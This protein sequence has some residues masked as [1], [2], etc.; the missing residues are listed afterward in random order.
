[1]TTYAWPSRRGK[2]ASA[3]LRRR[4]ARLRCTAPPIL[5]FPATTPTRGGPGSPAATITTTPPLRRRLPVRKTRR[6]AERPRREAYGRPLGGDTLPP[7][8]TPALQNRPSGTSTHPGTK[9]MLSLA[10]PNI[11]LI[12]AFHRD[13]GFEVEVREKV[14]AGRSLVKGVQA[15]SPVRWTTTGGEA[16]TL[17][18]PREKIF[19]R[20]RKAVLPLFWGPARHCGRCSA[21][22]KRVAPWVNLIRHSVGKGR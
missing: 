6:K 10:S 17:E 13:P 15:L 18:A 1:M 19:A 16:T 14:T 11:G 3:S 2:A 8:G 12:G 9:A 20:T 22:R 4:F 21:G 7:F 5:F